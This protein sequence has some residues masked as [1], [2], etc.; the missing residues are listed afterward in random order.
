[1]YRGAWWT[2]V[3]WVAESDMT[4]WLTHTHNRELTFHLILCRTNELPPSGQ[5]MWQSWLLPQYAV[6]LPFAN[7][8]HPLCHNGQP[9][10]KISHNSSTTGQSW[11]LKPIHSGYFFKTFKSQSQNWD[12]FLWSHRAYV[13]QSLRHVRLCNSLDCSIPGFSVPH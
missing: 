12:Y 3:L 1:M 13:V 8:F 7:Q 10:S 5:A 2:I 6:T 11:W 4:R 9:R